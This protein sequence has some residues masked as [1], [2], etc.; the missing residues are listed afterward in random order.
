MSRE[1]KVMRN[2]EDPI[3]STY[4]KIYSFASGERQNRAKKAFEEGKY[5]TLEEALNA[6]PVP[7]VMS[8]VKNIALNRSMTNIPL[9]ARIEAIDYVVTKIMGITPIQFYSIWNTEDNK[10]YYL[11]P[12]I[13]AIA[14]AAPPEYWKECYFDS[15]LVF[16]K[17]TW[18]DVY[19]KRIKNVDCYDIYYCKDNNFK[20]SLKRAGST[21][22]IS[23][24][25]RATNRGAEVDDILFTAI[26]DVVYDKL[27]F[28]TAEEI[29]NYLA[30]D[31]RQY[32]DSKRAR[33][34]KLDNPAPGICEIIEARGYGSLY[35]FFYLKC[36]KHFQMRYAEEFLTIRRAY[37]LPPEPLIETAIETMLEMNAEHE[38]MM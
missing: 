13:N 19:E 30:T 22:N 31:S 9:S 37:E 33:R 26:C 5:A 15:K 28:D 1:A 4:Y 36:P 17:M 8:V 34:A 6:T 21:L 23:E 35:D 24:N 16:F 7:N 18:P 12:T 20:A 2:E 11:Y 25:R 29:F 38:N 14:N 32:V 3:E 10:R 27:E